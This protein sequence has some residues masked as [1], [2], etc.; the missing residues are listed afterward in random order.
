LVW[1]RGLLLCNR[2][3]FV[4]KEIAGKQGAGHQQEHQEVKKLIHGFICRLD[5]LIQQM[6]R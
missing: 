1:R 3:L 6:K 5:E 2:Y 4:K